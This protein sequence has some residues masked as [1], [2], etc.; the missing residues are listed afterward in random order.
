MIVLDVA[1]MRA[2]DAREGAER[3]GVTLMREAGAAI[4][5]LVPRYA[6]GKR[7]AGIA[8]PGN[9][10]GDAFAALAELPRNH[11]RIA[12]A[13]PAQHE[14]AARKDAVARA[15]A[16]GVE[17]RYFE[18][19]ADLHGLAGADLILDGI[20][21]VGSRL[22]LSPPLDGAVEAINASGAP[23]LAIDL[24]SGIDAS[25]GTRATPCVEATATLT[26][27]ALKL[28]LLLDPAREN[29]GD[30]WLA[31]IGF[32]STYEGVVAHAL[33]DAELRALIPQRQQA[34]EKRHA[35][36]PLLL[37]G[38]EQ[39]SGAAVL[40]ARAA[41]RAGAGYVTVA[42][43]ERAAPALRAQLVEQTI[44]TYDPRDVEESVETILDVARRYGSLAIGPGLGASDK[45]GA[46]VREVIRRSDLPMV[47]DATGLFHLAK[48]LDV[49]HRKRAVITP[50][51]GEFARLSGKGIVAEEERI[52]RLRAFVQEHSVVTL[53]KGRATLVY[54]GLAMHV[55]TTGT[56]ALATAGT[57]DVLTGMIGTLLSQGL[58]PVDAAR[59]AAHWHGIAGQIAAAKRRIGAIAGDVIDALA[60]AYG[61]HCEEIAGPGV[62]RIG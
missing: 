43:P 15:A 37:T 14:S 44:V 58:S 55:N 34:T 21:G 57:G 45:M 48:H 4:A 5:A 26:I 16:S 6:R 61:R 8:G 47:I 35:G 39:F 62:I 9:N 29:V 27:G 60:E 49:L 36:A 1:G 10:G 56:S 32:P 20:L 28:G 23:V 25:N 30:L 24:P 17:I 18:R 52:A 46:I 59:A 33:D 3:T 50:H 13:L 31:P 54:D 42:I 11:Q 41:A 2:L 51:A 19:A 7:I 53:L 12:Y 38:S 40:C 22:P